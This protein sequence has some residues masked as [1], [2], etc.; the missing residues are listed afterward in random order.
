[1]SV[2]ASRPLITGMARAGTV[3]LEELLALREGGDSVLDRC[4]LRVVES[5]ASNCAGRVA[6]FNAALPDRAQ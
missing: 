1:M 2:E 6:A 3:P 4:L 5:A